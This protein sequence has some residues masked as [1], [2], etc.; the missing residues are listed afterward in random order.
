M[1]HAQLEAGCVR[2]AVEK[3]G[4][5]AGL[6]DTGMADAVDHGQRGPVPAQHML[7]GLRAEDGHVV[8][9]VHGLQPRVQRVMVAVGPEDGDA[10]G[11]QAQAAVAQGQLGFDAV[12]F[13]IVDV[14]G[15][16]EEVRPQAF[17]Q[18]EQA[19]Q[20]REGGVAQ[21]RLQGLPGIGAAQAQKGGV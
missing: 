16:D 18:V 6:P 4:Q 5:I 10:A 3:E 15:Q 2:L 8:G 12:L 20:G 11:L 14:P 21:L 7:L 9:P 19:L 17:A 13:L 1:Q